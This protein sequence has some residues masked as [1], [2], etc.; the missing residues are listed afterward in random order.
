MNQWLKNVRLETGEIVHSNNRIETTTE[1]F[2]LEISHDGHI[3]DIVQATAPVNASNSIDLEGQLALPIFKEMHNHLD[4]TYLSLDWKACRPVK[5]LKERLHY[6]AQ[7][8]E[9]LSE[10][11]EQRASA[12]IEKIIANGVNHIR[13]HINVDPYIG[14]KNLEGVVKALKKYKDFV[15]ADI[16][17]FPQ[18]GLMR[19]DVPDL[20]RKALENGAT[21]L[22]GLDPGGI[23]GDI[24]NSL[25]LTMQIAEEY[26]V[27]V[28]IHL[29]DS[30]YLG[31]YTIDKWIDLIEEHNFGHRTDFSHAFSLG[32][33]SV[34]EQIAI[35]KRLKKHD[36]RIMSTVPFN[37][38]RVIP[39]IDLLT[40][41]G[42]EVHFGFDGFYDSWSPY[43]SGDI[44]EKANIFA[45]VTRK[46][47]E[48]GLRKSLGYIT[49]HITPLNAQGQQQWPKI[50]DEASF[51]FVPVSCSAEAVARLPKQRTV[52]NKGK[53][54]N[55]LITT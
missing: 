42:V 2:H 23:D 55:S 22:G 21:M 39:P 14:L 54:F 51:V 32:D 8:L 4:K 24:E 16:I 1:L 7:E 6:E 35:A 20:L 47:D 25:R 17:A 3:V 11:I 46:I 30:G 34:P 12:M 50:G 10:S 33:V 36:I 37:L 27:D 38:G 52:M 53:L 13:T 48:R 44:L 49:N 18:H 19:D 26:G 40:E 45:D 43:G 31:Y 41:H 29:H 5:N 9:L 28:D 15:T